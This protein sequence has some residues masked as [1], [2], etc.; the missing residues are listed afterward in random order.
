MNNIANEA[1]QRAVG[2]SPKAA[3]VGPRYLASVGVLL[4]IVIAL[5]ALLW[6]R[7]RRA[8][9]AAEV[10]AARWQEKSKRLSGAV[11]DLLVKRGGQLIQPIQRGDLPARVVD[12]DGQRRTVLEVGALAGR[13]LGFQPGDLVLVGGEDSETQPAGQQ[14]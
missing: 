10:N 1:P 9:I 14:P 5:L 6:M 11:G 7:E 4:V 13:R 8:R 3:Q 12:L 2:Q